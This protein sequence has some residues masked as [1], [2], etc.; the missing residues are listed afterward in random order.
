MS[1]H[2]YEYVVDLMLRIEKELG[3]PCDLMCA[4]A[5]PE[6][7]WSAILTLPS[8][9]STQVTTFPQAQEWVKKKAKALGGI[10]LSPYVPDPPNP[11][12]S[13]SDIAPVEGFEGVQD[14]YEEVTD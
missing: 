11:V 2:S 6:G 7:S 14:P 12:K 8:G 9:K 5:T 13:E 10:L 4:L 3:Y 1:R